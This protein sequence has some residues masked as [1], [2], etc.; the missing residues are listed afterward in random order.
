MDF[1]F[2]HNW[3]STA[4]STNSKNN[5]GIIE[6]IIEDDDE[7]EIIDEFISLRDLN[8]IYSLSSSYQI[9][10]SIVEIAGFN[11]EKSLKWVIF[12]K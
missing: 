12:V 11:K 8:E 1:S 4:G 5:D 6:S 3:F 7:F 2:L 10:E 9:G